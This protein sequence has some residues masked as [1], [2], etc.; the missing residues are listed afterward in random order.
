MPDGSEN[1]DSWRTGQAGF[2]VGI[3]AT[4]KDEIT[5]QGDV[6]K[7]TKRTEPEDSPFDGQ[8]I[9]ARWTRSI[10][11][12][13]DFALQLYFDRYWRGDISTADQLHTY[14]LDFQH[15][16]SIDSKQSILWGLGYRM[17]H[18]KVINRSTSAGLVPNER[19]MPLYSGFIQDEIQLR[20]NVKV[21]IGSKFLH[22][23]FSGFEFQPSARA[24]WNVNALNTLW[25]AVS[26]AIRAPSRFDID[27]RLPIEPQPANVPSV[28]GGPNFDS[29]KLYAYELGYRVQPNSKV[30]LSLAS[31][32]NDYNDVYSVEPLPGT[33]TYQIQNGSV[34]QTWG[35]IFRVCKAVRIMEVEGRV[36]LFW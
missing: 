31:F 29:E 34:A 1:K 35:G 14:D 19:T 28:A 30:S 32:Y 10:S 26:R 25:V 17:V 18:D 9:M 12:K 8:N 13:S 6:Y 36:H 22:N 4:S 15:R 33:L 16:F 20:E 11:E 2:Q 3:N 21:T 5:L 23:I 27:Y 7:G 24:A